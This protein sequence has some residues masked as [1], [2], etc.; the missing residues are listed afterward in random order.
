MKMVKNYLEATMG[1]ERIRN[2]TLIHVQKDFVFN[3]YN[4]I[5]EFISKKNKGAYC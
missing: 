5:T 4:D 2:F 3:F 1:Q